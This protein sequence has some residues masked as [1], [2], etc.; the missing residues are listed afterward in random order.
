[1]VTVIGGSENNVRNSAVSGTNTV[2][3]ASGRG[4]DLFVRYGIGNLRA[5]VST[6][7]LNNNSYVTEGETGLAKKRGWMIVSDYDFN[8][9]YVAAMYAQ[10]KIQGGNYENVTKVLSDSHGW[11]LGA[12]VPFGEDKRHTIM[13]GYNSLTDESQLHRSAKLYGGAYWYQLEAAT[14]VYAS[15]GQIKNNANA[16]YALVD[17][18]NLV[19]SISAPGVKAS[20]FEVGLN[21]N[22]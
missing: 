3:D 21:Y 11:Y 18:G 4:W 6:W 14:R 1:M 22:F 10:G 13:V 7:N 17:A 20:G 8:F 12:R 16:S 5:G 15:W 19:G 9:M 2:T